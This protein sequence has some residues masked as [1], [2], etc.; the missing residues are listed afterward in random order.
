[1][2][3]SYAFQTDVLLMTLRTDRGNSEYRN[4]PEG[5]INVHDGIA[6]GIFLG[7]TPF[8]RTVPNTP[9]DLAPRVWEIR[10]TTDDFVPINGPRMISIW[11]G[12]KQVYDWVPENIFS[13]QIGEAHQFYFPALK[14]VRFDEIFSPLFPDSRIYKWCKECHSEGGLGQKLL[15]LVSIILSFV[16]CLFR[17]G[18]TFILA[19]GL[20]LYS[21]S[22]KDYAE[23]L[24]FR[25]QINQHRPANNLITK[26]FH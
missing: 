7:N 18:I 6:L 3:S 22:N 17:W 14:T 2:Q 12:V 19:R 8:V 1:M 25:L 24:R 11:E 5:Y 21:F 13:P 15:F 26:L 4:T 23:Y 9:T 10:A 16:E 20:D